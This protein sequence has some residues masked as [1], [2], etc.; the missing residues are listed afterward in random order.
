MIIGYQG[1][2]HSY[3]YRAARALFPDA[4]LKGHPSF[5][6]AFRSLRES[7]VS[8]LVLPIANSTTGPILPVLDRLV[9]ADASIKAEHVIH[10]R[11][12]LLGVPGATLDD[13]KSVRSHPVALGQA[14][15]LLEER[16]WEAVAT[17]DT[18]GAVREVAE[19]QDPSELALA[20]PAAGEAFG[21]EVLMEDAIDQDHNTTRFV[22]LEPGKHHVREHD[23]KTSIAFETPHTP[24]ALAMALTELGLRGANLT[25]IE[26]RPGG[27]LWRY[28]YYVDFLH[29]PGPPG[30][31][32]ILDPTPMALSNIH[33]LGSY[34]AVVE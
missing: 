29:E 34:P 15:A 27:K 33:M 21:L 24:G 31:A 28:M 5:V 2:T 23:N 6:R 30:L 8:F 20:D 26:S 16:G 11:H 19:H 25:M 10:V 18:A 9:S 14:E 7:A 1:E 4:E 12:A 3:S 13:A 22:V 17:S 32:K